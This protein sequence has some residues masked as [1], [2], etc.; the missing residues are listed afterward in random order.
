MEDIKYQNNSFK[1]AYRV[2]AI[3]YNF[4][5]TK[6]L[7]FTGNDSGYYMLPGGKVKELEESIEAIKREILEETGFEN[8]EF[9]L[10]GISEEIIKNDKDNIQQI[11]FTYA[12]TYSKKID[13]E[14]FKSIESDWINFKWVKIADLSKYKIHPN[15]V[16]NMLDGDNIKKITHIVENKDFKGRN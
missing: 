13:N 6:I 2:S 16:V 7:L 8:L 12:T 10:T 5:K 14:E 1:F 3:I 4:D 9:E 15:C 11:T